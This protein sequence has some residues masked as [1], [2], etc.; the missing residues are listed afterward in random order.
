[1]GAGRSGRFVALDG[2][3]ASIPD[4]ARVLVGSGCG[5]PTYLADALAHERSRWDRLHVV[6]GYLFE[7]LAL[8]EHAGAPF[9]VTSLHPTPALRGLPAEHLDTVP[10]RYGDLPAALAPGA[11][12]APDVV[13]VQV[14]PID[15]SGRCS[16]GVSVGGVIDAVR[17]APLVIAQVNASAP[18]VYGDG[19][20]DPDD[21]DLLVEADTPLVGMSDAPLSAEVD[22]IGQH[23]AGEVGDGATVQIGVG[24]VPG[25]VLAALDG[26][27]RLR[28][29]G[30][31]F[32]SGCRRLVEVGAVDGTCVAAEVMGDADL[33]AWVDHNPVV[34]TVSAR[35]SHGLGTLLALSKFVAIN[36]ALE[37]DV[38]G[39]V[40]GEFGDD[41][42]LVSGPGGLPDFVNAALAT[43]DGTSVIALPARSA[44]GSRRRI[45]PSLGGR[46][47]LPAFLA[48]RVVTDRGIA[49]LRG[50]SRDER[51]QALD[52]IS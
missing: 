34:R 41:G 23:V 32:T 19:E 48:D 18:Y 45:V 30:G 35:T 6:T 15:G 44:D 36:S 28:L 24:R 52:A 33:F 40:N 39:A 49:R 51:R 25:A 29:H 26:R 46:V 4:R 8:F 2:A 14:S 27:R 5:V 43:A 12:H 11:V 38:E 47:T 31:M 21:I 3:L 10:L 9:T 7:P 16:L 13:L 1:M 37:V 17:T 50:R 20:L 22:A 42:R